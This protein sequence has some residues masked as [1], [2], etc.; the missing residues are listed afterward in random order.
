MFE[1]DDASSFLMRG[2]ISRETR[3][4]IKNCNTEAILHSLRGVVE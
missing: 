4:R 3:H 2:Q 1:F